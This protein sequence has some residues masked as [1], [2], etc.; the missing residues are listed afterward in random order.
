MIHKTKKKKTSKERLPGNIASK[1]MKPKQLQGE[2]D[3]AS[4]VEHLHMPCLA[5]FR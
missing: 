2:L 4:Q 5:N 3:K 1:Y